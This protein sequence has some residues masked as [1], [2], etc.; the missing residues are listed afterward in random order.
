MT[1]ILHPLTQ[2]QLRLNG[3]SPSVVTLLQHLRTVK[4]LNFWW[5][6]TNLPKSIPALHCH[7]PKYLAQRAI[8]FHTHTHSGIWACLLAVYLGALCLLLVIGQC[9]RRGRRG[10]MCKPAMLCCLVPLCDRVC[11]SC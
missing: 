10:R 5:L 9:G 11:C 2:R 8:G 7:T 6:S 3:S 1:N 4:L